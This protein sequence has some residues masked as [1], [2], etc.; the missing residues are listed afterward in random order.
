[1]RVR[2]W[3]PSLVTLTDGRVLVVGG[4]IAAMRPQRVEPSLNWARELEIFDPSAKTWEYV[5]DMPWSLPYYPRI[6][7]LPGGKIFYGG[8]GTNWGPGGHSADAYWWAV[9]QN[10]DPATGAW[11]SNGLATHGARSG[12][13]S[14][15]LR[16]E[17]PYD[18]ARIL[19]AGG[20]LGTVGGSWV[21]NT[22]SEVTTLDR[23]AKVVD[24][25]PVHGPLDGLGGDESQLRQRRWFGSPVLLPT[26]EVLLLNGSDMD[27]TLA[28]GSDGPVR[29]PELFD[30]ATNTWRQVAPAARDRA[31]HST[32]VLLADGRV[33]VGGH[34]PLH[35]VLTA[36]GMEFPGGRITPYRDSTFEIY[37]PP[38]L[39][40]GARPEIEGIIA[41]DGGKSALVTLRAATNASDVDQVVLVRLG[42][43]THQTD[44][45]MRAVVLPITARAEGS[46]TVSLPL[47][48]DASVVPPGPY[49]LFAMR[50][51]PSGP[52]PSVAEVVMVHPDGKGA[53]VMEPTE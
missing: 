30:P 37:S 46:V 11:G 38:Y 34:V 27:G 35:P 28:P 6:H 22:L 3:Y 2:R 49:Y 52:V 39:F 24:A 48:G 10:Y 7:L 43:I 44:N 41:G 51:S 21:A 33:L 42:A 13:A 14:V 5:G 1:M 17:P 31:Y 50:R 45:D 23:D 32:A 20:T 36:A 53:V 40:R 8:V 25:G 47:D 26:G 19:M 29:A 18:R 4:E 12:A 16:L 9:R 15:L